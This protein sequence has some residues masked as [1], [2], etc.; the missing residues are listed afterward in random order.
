MADNNAMWRSG[1]KSSHQGMLAYSGKSELLSQ[2]HS[3]TCGPAVTR[4]T[5]VNETARN[6]DWETNH[7]GKDETRR[8]LLCFIEENEKIKRN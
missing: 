5:T 8:F 6:G 1:L 2:Q 7:G 3:G 4:I